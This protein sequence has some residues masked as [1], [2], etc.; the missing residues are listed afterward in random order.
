MASAVLAQTVSKTRVVDLDPEKSSTQVAVFGFPLVGT[1][2][3]FPEAYTQVACGNCTEKEDIDVAEN[4]FMGK[5]PEAR[6]IYLKPTRLPDSENPIA[7]FTTTLH[8]TLESGY[9]VNI[10]LSLADIRGPQKPD[11]EVEFR[12]AKQAT[13]AG[14]LAERDEQREAEFKERVER[15][16]QALFLRHMLGKVECKDKWPVAKRSD[17]MYLRV[18]QL[19]STTGKNKVHWAVFEVH[20]RGSQKLELDSAAIV[21]SDGSSTTSDQVFQFGNEELRFDDRTVGVA[22]ASMGEGEAL[23]EK[24]DLTVVE[25]GG[26]EREV[27][28]TGLSF[29]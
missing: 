25:R 18:H 27:S 17:K 9:R 26:A 4:W 22:L 29:P 14:R 16:A 8:V 2:L 24:W 10:N 28:A 23:P 7:A 6:T 11:A 5:S 19:C 15:E 13:M 20:N 12:L 1:A 21:P 3:V